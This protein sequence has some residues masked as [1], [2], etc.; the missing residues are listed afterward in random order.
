MIQIQTVNFSTNGGTN[1][2]VLGNA[3][4]F[5]DFT[6]AVRFTDIENDTSTV[7]HGNNITTGSIQST[8][9]TASGSAS[10][11]FAQTGSRI[12]LSDGSIEAE[13]FVIDSSGNAQFRG[14]IKGNLAVLGDASVGASAG[15]IT[16]LSDV[17]TST[18]TD[19]SDVIGGPQNTDFDIS[20]YLNSTLPYGP[21][22]LNSVST[23]A[24]RVAVLRF[25]TP[26]HA[27]IAYTNTSNQQVTTDTKFYMVT[28]SISPV[29]NFTSSSATGGYGS[30][31]SAGGP[32]RYFGLAL[33]RQD[34]NY[35][36]GT[37]SITDLNG[38]TQNASAFVVP[39]VAPATD[40]GALQLP[41]TYS[42]TS[43]SSGVFNSIR[44][45]S[46]GT[47]T[48]ADPTTLSARY[49]LMGNNV[50]YVLIY[51]FFA[52][53]NTLSNQRGFGNITITVNGLGI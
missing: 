52:Q 8:G 1:S 48:V 13:N 39:N 37:Q 20:G 27:P 34:S 50:Y 3:S 14:Q 42:E 12:N 5:V 16:G 46:Q 25:Q 4:T 47:A 23:N 30:S 40:S 10:D 36:S 24:T 21:I 28:C 44:L 35:P 41:G 31:G 22:T 17:L 2:F 45:F 26:K 15:T 29:G 51:G 6:R 7:I 32:Q 11:P 49:T 18:S 38:T 33:S 19:G 9:F 53:I 43:G